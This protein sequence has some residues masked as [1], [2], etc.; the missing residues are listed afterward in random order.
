MPEETSE[1]VYDDPDEE[2]AFKSGQK[3]GK[4]DGYYTGI[5]A[6]GKDHDIKMNFLA[7]SYWSNLKDDDAFKNGYINGWELM[8]KIGKEEGYNE[9][10]SNNLY[11]DKSFF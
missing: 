9:E 4:I 5:I 7:G 10:I 11:S 2:E 3:I 1:P 8:Y 6:H